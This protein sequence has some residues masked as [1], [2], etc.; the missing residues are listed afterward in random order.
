MQKEYKKQPKILLWEITLKFKFETTHLGLR[1]TTSEENKIKVNDRIS[2]ARRTLCSL[3]KTGVHGTNGLNPRTSCKI[4]KVYVVPRILYELE[5]L[6]LQNKDLTALCR[7]HLFLKHIET[8]SISCK[9]NS[10][11][12][13]LLASRSTADKFRAPQKTVES[14]TFNSNE[15]K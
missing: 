15:S 4:Y 7:F 13:N 14:S 1:R 9:Q 3:I 6:D 2:L 12:S 10:N 11:I 8:Y 5:T